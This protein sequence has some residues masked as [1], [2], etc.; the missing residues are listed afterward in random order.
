M[1]FTLAFDHVLGTN[2]LSFCLATKNENK[3]I[4][5][6]CYRPGSLKRTWIYIIIQIF[7][8]VFNVFDAF[9]KKNVNVMFNFNSASW[10][11]R[12]QQINFKNVSFEWHKIKE[13]NCDII[14]FLFR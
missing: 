12:W 1:L 3:C 5:N 11:S 6:G 13:L 7:Y 8:Q 9:K 2:T 14:L 10:T 4:D